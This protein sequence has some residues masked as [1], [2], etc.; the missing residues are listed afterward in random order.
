M[1]APDARE[2]AREIADRF[3]STQNYTPLIEAIAAKLESATAAERERAARIV[4]TCQ[5]GDTRLC[6]TI[7]TAI[8]SGDPTK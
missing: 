1:S 6:L 5:F 7:A 3:W 8:R 2:V 4:E